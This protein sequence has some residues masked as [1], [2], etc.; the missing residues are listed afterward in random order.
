MVVGMDRRN[1]GSSPMRSDGVARG[2]GNGAGRIFRRRRGGADWG[3]RL[4][5]LEGGERVK[6]S[7]MTPEQ[8]IAEVKALS[9][10]LYGSDGRMR[11]DAS[12]DR[13]PVKVEL[14]SD[15]WDMGFSV[16]GSSILEA[17]RALA[18]QV[19]Q[20]A[21]DKIRRLRVAMGEDLQ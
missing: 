6:V 14:S 3:A 16:E 18:E 10:E 1:G 13:G 19:R 8:A 12:M 7:E 2:L 20:A 4:A 5:R 17:T 15:E 9:R 11:I 21:S